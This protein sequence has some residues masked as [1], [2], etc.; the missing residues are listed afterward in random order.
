[1]KLRIG[2]KIQI[3]FSSVLLLLLLMAGMSY[4]SLQDSK[5]ELIVIEQTSHRAI[6]I[7]QVQNE[8]RQGV[9][10]IRGY[11]AYGDEKFY[12]QVES[13]MDNTLKLEQELLALTPAEQKG[14][15]EKLIIVTTKYKDGLIKDLSPIV[16]THYQ[17][18]QAGQLQ[19]AQALKVS[20]NEIARTLIP[21]TDELGTIVAKVVSENQNAEASSMLSAKENI[22]NMLTTSSYLSIVALLVGFGLSFVLS[23]LITKPILTMLT[24]ANRYATGDLRSPIVITSSDELGELAA[25]LNK[26]RE[27]ISEI[28]QNIK[29]NIGSAADHIAASAEELT[30]NAHQ[31]AK[32]SNEVAAAIVDIAQGAKVQLDSA[33][34]TSTYTTQMAVGMRGIADN[35][36]SMAEVSRSASK[37]AQTGG[38][39]VETAMKQ[40]KNIELSVS[41][42]A[43]AISRLEV[44]SGQIVEFANAIGGIAGQTNLL[45][46]NAAIEAARAGE[47]G[48]GF[49]VVAEE[50][51]KLAEDSQEAAKKIS[52]LIGEIRQDTTIAVETMTNGKKEVRLG[53]EVVTGAGQAFSQI[54]TMVG[55]VADQVNQVSVAVDQM[56]AESTQITNSMGAI[57]T[58]SRT[59]ANQTQSA[60]AAMQEQSASIEEI[61]TSCR[62]LTVLAEQLR[63]SVDQFKV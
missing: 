11:I 2:T 55:Q 22:S 40:M 10:G 34:N 23:R 32:T 6:L 53:T 45:A 56:A 58:T 1:M 39:A 49:A 15:M 57:E 3:S 50:V 63:S 26:M 14:N 18:A 16:R 59:A 8:F 46:L 38:Q 25:S 43:E 37:A 48:R 7:L 29:S 31:S 42:L 28:I 54:N 61:A 27:R 47:Q 19:E 60:S 62:E 35:M 24:S 9:A 17:A 44:R 21:L 20:F 33:S 12:H 30:A 5:K 13:A 4:L 41:A 51:R 36:G 52:T